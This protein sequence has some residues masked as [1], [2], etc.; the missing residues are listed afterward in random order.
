MARASEL[1]VK[2]S[3]P[4]DA[5][6]LRKI[7]FSVL[8]VPVLCECALG[9]LEGAIKYRR[10]NFRVIGVRASVYYDA[11]IRHLGAW[12]EG[13]DIDADSGLNHITKAITSLMVLRDAMIRDKM[14]DDRPPGTSGFI[15]LLNDRA[16]GILDSFDEIKPPYTSQDVDG[17]DEYS[18]LE[19][20]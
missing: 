4:K 16:A 11:T 7:P 14:V 6:G 17:P 12:W 13:E 19:A 1:S 15:K 10:H 8:S 3:N 2:S 9:L 5:I 18:G 20:K